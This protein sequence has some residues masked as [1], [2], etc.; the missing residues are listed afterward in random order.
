MESLDYAL[1]YMEYDCPKKN[2]IDID[3]VLDL[4]RPKLNKNNIV[5]A[6]DLDKLTFDNLNISSKVN[7]GK[8]T[9]NIKFKNS[10]P[11]S[12]R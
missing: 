2:V 10:E 1:N 11:V 9:D 6:R 4:S 12:E 5:F 7:D 8:D 3:E